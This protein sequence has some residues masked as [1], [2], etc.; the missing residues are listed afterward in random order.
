[1]G[2]PL[3]SE[4]IGAFMAVGVGFFFA[5]GAVIARVGL[6]HVP[7]GTGS[8][9]TIVVGWVPITVISAVL[10]PKL[11]FTLPATA[12]LWMALTG[13]VNFPVARFL[14]MASLKILGVGKSTPIL[15]TAPLYAAF[16]G[17][18][19]L[20]E[21]MTWPIA[22]GTVVI[23]GG[24]VFVA[25]SAMP[26]ITLTVPAAPAGVASEALPPPRTLFGFPRIMVIGY[27][28]GLGAAVAYGIMPATYQVAMNYTHNPF[29]TGSLT[30]FFGSIFMAMLVGPRIGT[31]LRMSPRRSLLFVGAGGLSM[32]VGT[33]LFFLAV[34]RT[35]IIVVSPLISLQPVFALAGAHL[36]LQRLEKITL[37]LVLG[38]LIIVGGVLAI[39]FGIET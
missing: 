7:A 27:V 8:L 19:F 22:L 21:T 26:R 14:N 12:Y 33:I 1:V 24:V 17:V 16:V 11:V 6:V 20:D 23:V 29:A 39:T 3:P 18:V 5:T 32:T 10:Y 15:A 36:F 34:E 4:I 35:P 25:K 9:V 31:D 13:A 38:T 37:P 30:L 28:L 2:G